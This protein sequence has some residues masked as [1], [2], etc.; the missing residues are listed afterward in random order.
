MSPSVRRALTC[1]LTALA[2]SSGCGDYTQAAPPPALL[3][4]PQE[5]RLRRGDSFELVVALWI[6]TR[7]G[8]ADAATLSIADTTVARMT[9]SRRVLALRGGSTTVTARLVHKGQALIGTGAISVLVPA[10]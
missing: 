2:V 8:E 3:F 5:L 7:V 10:Q 4:E 9:G 6:G 1:G